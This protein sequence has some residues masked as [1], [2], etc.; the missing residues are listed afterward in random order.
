[1]IPVYGLKTK[2]VLPTNSYIV[3]QA[4]GHRGILQECAFALLTLTRTHTREA[5]KNLEI[6]IYTDSPE[7]FNS[8]RDCP[9]NLTLKEI[10]PERIRSW[11][12]SIDFVHRMK[13]ELLLDFVQHKTGQVLYLDTDVYFSG[14]VVEMFEKI[15]EGQLYMHI[16][17]GLIHESEHVMLQK[18][19]RFLKK[20]GNL[21]WAGKTLEIPSRETMWNAGVLGFHT[22]HSPLLKEVL[23]FTDQVYPLFP[24]HIVEQFAFSHYFQHSAEI[25]TAHTQIYHYWNLKEIRTILASFFKYFEKNT[26][27]ELSDLSR[28]IQLP[29]PM[30]QKVNFLQNR[31]PLEKFMKKQWK[32]VEPRWDL[33]L[34]QL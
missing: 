10:N 17:E 9:L 15:S 32:P 14:S 27:D 3:F 18:L 34:Q 1:M 25:K 30:Q 7:F 4:Y 5:L 6:C 11:R 16:M 23:E 28:L 26:W 22:N 21:Q 8:F 24:K 12:G 29:D 19:S 31:T 2:M 13:I 20:R 33:L